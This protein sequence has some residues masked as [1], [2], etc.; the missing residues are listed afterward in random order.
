MTAKLRRL[1]RRIVRRLGMRLAYQLTQ[2]G[3]E[4]LE[5]II[6]ASSENKV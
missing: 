3:I 4:N 5:E 1:Q 6:P 2:V